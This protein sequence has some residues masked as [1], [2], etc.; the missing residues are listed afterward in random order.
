MITGLFHKRLSGY[1]GDH[2]EVDMHRGGYK[3]ERERV[4]FGEH[5]RSWRMVLNLTAQQV[6]ERGD[7]SR[8][9]LRKV[10][11]GDPGV[12]FG[13]VTQVLRALGQLDTIVN[14]ADPFNSDIGRLRARNILR[15]RA[16]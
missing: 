7:I 4:Q 13:S 1:L 11:A 9:T 14:A 2:K 6:S 8:T 15:K 10:E 5:I 12:S 3:I 16:R